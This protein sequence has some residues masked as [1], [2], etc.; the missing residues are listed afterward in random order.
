MVDTGR[1]TVSTTTPALARDTPDAVC[2]A[3]VDL[4]RAAALAE[5]G[6]TVG[7]HLGV[8]AEGERLVTH[9]FASTDPAYVG[10]RWAVTLARASRAR[11]AT[12]DEVVLLPGEGALLAPEWVPWSDRLRPGD[13]GVGDLLPPDA[14]DDRL[15]P[16]YAADDDADADEVA[17]GARPRPAAGAVP[18][19]GA[20]RPP[21][22]GTTATRGPTAA[23]A[24]AAPAPCGDLRLPRSRWPASL[25]SVFGVCANEFS[26]DDGRV[27]SLDHGCG[28]PLRDRRWPPPR[29]QQPR[30]ST[31]Y[32]YDVIEAGRQRGP[33]GGAVGGHGPSW[34]GDADAAEP[35]GHS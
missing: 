30:S 34:V 5:G 10:W 25:R 3:A 23:I 18:R 12:L 4:A 2:A 35:F 21:S 22:A 13:L 32:G 31:S 14:D 11:V 8:E 28:A 27:V 7:E 9:L 24:K 1:V 15:V 19:S 20:T 6:A 26:P 29:R 16:S 33:R 17:L